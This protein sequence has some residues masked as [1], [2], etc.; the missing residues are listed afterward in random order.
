MLP[1]QPRDTPGPQPASSEG[2]ESWT[3]L[4]SGAPGPPDL[5]RDFG[6]A[7]RQDV[8]PEPHLG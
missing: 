5:W 8:R 1:T 2:Q 7:P 4:R 6:R 3:W